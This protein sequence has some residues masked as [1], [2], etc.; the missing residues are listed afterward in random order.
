V[1]FMRKSLNLMHS[2]R[3]ASFI[4]TILAIMLAVLIMVLLPGCQNQPVTP[5]NNNP[6]FNQTIN[7]KIDNLTNINN[8]PKFE[9]FM[10]N[11]S[12]RTDAKYELARDDVFTLSNGNFTSLEVSILGIKLGD[13]YESVIKNLGIPDLTFIPAD[14]S[15]KNMEYRQKIGIGGLDSAVSYHIVNDTVVQISVR[16]SFNKYLHGNT[17]MG[18]P[19]EYVYSQIGIPDYQDFLSNFRVFHYI[20]RGVEIY[21]R[22]DKTSIISFIPPKQFKGVKWVSMPE[23]VAPG[24][25]VNRTVAVLID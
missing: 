23:E 7:E 18:K 20:T 2:A 14:K 21:L 12:D 4:P 3:G 25:F 22:V 11:Y 16:E 6:L 13:S 1:I 19:K 24:Y 17:T 9:E 8:T 15:Y 10:F 5:A